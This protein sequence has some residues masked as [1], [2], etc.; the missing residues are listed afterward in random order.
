MKIAISSY[1]KNIND[2]LN[3]RFG[4]C[5]FFQIYDTINNKIKVIEN[6]GLKSEG[7]AGIAASQQLVDENID[8]L[9][10]G[11]LGP[12]AFEI[13]EKAKILVYKSE[14]TSVKDALEKF[15]NNQLP[16]INTSGLPH[17]GI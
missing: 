8:V 2:L 16:K 7:G 6:D 17:Q 14:E 13:I 15:K 10:T 11:N 5:E 4:R 1:G 12:N 3:K 9:L